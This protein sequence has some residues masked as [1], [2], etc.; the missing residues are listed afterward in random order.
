MPNELAGLLGNKYTFKDK[1]GTGAFSQVYQ[2]ACNATGRAKAVKVINPKAVKFGSESVEVELL[3]T[4]SHPNVIALEEVLHLEGRRA[5]TA[6]VFPAFDLDLRQLLRLRRGFPLDFPN[7]HRLLI[8]RG[9]WVGVAY[10]HSRQILHR[11]IK[12]ANI[13]IR[14]GSKVHAVLADLGLATNLSMPSIFAGG[15]CQLRNRFCAA[16]H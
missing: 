8:A 5:C 12:P 10:L 6:L 3:Q 16:L 2:A 1:L 15:R 9:I 4:C 14:F 13:L 7:E 11:D